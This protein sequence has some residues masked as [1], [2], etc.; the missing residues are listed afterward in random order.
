[1]C[2]AAA[3]AMA[4]QIGNKLDEEHILP[5]MDDWE[6]FPREA[7]AV[8]MKAQEQGLARLQSS[9]EAELKNAMAIIKRSRDLTHMMMKE[10][11]IPDAPEEGDAKPEIDV[12]TA[13]AGF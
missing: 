4:D 2:F 6:V 11:F 3:H 10:G 12:E 8:A 9:Y 7:A 1:M 5:N 13:N